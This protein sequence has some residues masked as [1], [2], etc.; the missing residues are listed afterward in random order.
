MI[1]IVRNILAK[2]QRADIIHVTMMV[3][4]KQRIRPVLIYVWEFLQIVKNILRQLHLA[5]SITVKNQCFQC[6]LNLLISYIQQVPCKLHTI[7][8]TIE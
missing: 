2:K 5:K 3:V 8:L 4:L 7:V 6:Q 1:T